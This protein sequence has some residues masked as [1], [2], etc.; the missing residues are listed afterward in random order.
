[1]DFAK[2]RYDCSLSI[3]IVLSLFLNSCDIFQ[4]V[5][6]ITG[7]SVSLS[8]PSSINEDNENAFAVNGTCSEEGRDVSV[9]VG[10][11]N[12]APQPICIGGLW[13]VVALNVSALPDGPV[14]VTADHTNANGQTAPQATDGIVKDVVD[15]MPLAYAWALSSP[16][17][18]STSNDNTPIVDLSGAGVENG[19]S[20]QVYD[21][22][23]CTNPVG[24][25]QFIIGG[26]TTHNDVSYATDG[27][28]DGA[29]DFYVVMTDGAGNPSPCSDVSLG[30]SLITFCNPALGPTYR[31][32]VDDTGSEGNSNSS[33]AKIDNSGRYVFFQSDATNLIPAD[34]NSNTDIFMKDR[35]T[36][37]VELIS[38]DSSEVQGNSSAHNVAISED[39]NYVVFDSAST[40]L[41]PVDTNA[42]RDVFLRDR[43]LGLT[44]RVSEMSGGGEASDYS[45]NPS[46][47]ADGRYIVF[48][49]VATDMVVGDLNGRRDIFL[50][51]RIANTT[52]LISV[53]SDE[54]QAT[55]HSFN[56]SVSSDGRF[57]AFQTIANNVVP[58]DTNGGTD[59]FVRD[60]LLGTT[61]RVSVS[62][63]ETEGNISSSVP[64][65]SKSGRFVVFESFASNLVSGDTNGTYDI[66]VRDRFLGITERVSVISGGGESNN[67]SRNPHISTDGNYIIFDSLA[68]NLVAGDTNGVSDI[69]VHDRVGSVTVRASLD[70]TDLF[71]ADVDAF[72]P[73]IS[74]D[75]RVVVYDSGATNLICDD[76]NGF[77]DVFGRDLQP[78]GLTVT[79][80]QA[81][82]Q[83]DPTNTT[84]VNFDVVFSSA[85]DPTSFTVADIVNLGSAQVDIWNINHVSGNTNFTI[86][87]ISVSSSG[88]IQP[89]IGMSLVYDPG[90]VLFN[91]ASTSVDGSVEF[92]VETSCDTI[93]LTACPNSC[94]AP[95]IAGFPYAAGTGTS[96]DPYVICTD[97]QMN[98][99]G[100][101][102]GDWNSHFRL[103]ADIDLS[104]FPGESYNVI[105]DL[106]T[107]FT[108]V[109]DGQGC[110]ISNLNYIDVS[111]VGILGVFGN[112]RC[113]YI[114]DLSLDVS[115][116]GRAR[117]GALAG[118]AT[119]G[120]FEN[121]DWTIGT[122]SGTELIGG[123]VGE[124]DSFPLTFSNVRSNGR[125]VNSATVAAPAVGGIVGAVEFAGVGNPTTCV[126]TEGGDYQSATAVM[127]I[128][129]I[130]SC[131]GNVESVD[132]GYAGGILG[133]IG[134]NA[135]GTHYI[136]NSFVSRTILPHTSGFVGVPGWSIGGGIFGQ[137]YGASGVIEVNKVGFVGTIEADSSIQGVDMGG[138]IGQA[139]DTMNI[140]N[141]YANA[142]IDNYYHRGGGAA[143]CT[144]GI[145]CG[146]AGI[147]IGGLIGDS[148]GNSVVL[149]RSYFNGTVYG[150]TG[151]AGILGNINNFFTESITIS[152]S[153]TVGTIFGSGTIIGND[154]GA[155]ATSSN[156]FWDDA[157]GLGLP[158]DPDN[159][160]GAGECQASGGAA[161]FNDYRNLPMGDGISIGDGTGTTWNFNSNWSPL[162]HLTVFP[163]LRL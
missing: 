47:S 133:V 66:F 135:V 23:V 5:A 119:K 138:L 76:T 92:I 88:T 16:A 102:P 148:P 116:S 125:V 6:G 31:F 4:K 162:G 112:T 153:F 13:S 120:R 80:E 41:I 86:Q 2:P 124:T 127:N 25:S 98:A 7:V 144:V 42:S 18:G 145:G 109:F 131:G 107:Q 146:G 60:R 64:T 24:S 26:A 74:S 40:N 72:R 136:T 51:D 140:Y 113:A 62:S 93:Q 108:G 14:V 103:K 126:G 77:G 22:F 39:G 158:C 21:D 37:T 87:A 69:F 147:H 75:G 35:L 123:I 49:S 30:Y 73:S 8:S 53:T 159:V 48:E 59:I 34:G 129:K 68:T 27:T 12:P 19:S 94:T 54:V 155:N 121:I 28:D 57:V 44:T 43:V 71:E 29:V 63:F 105:G 3:V 142:T 163:N 143:N 118:Y 89:Y 151:A 33:N 152:N 20:V 117:V 46:I 81:V 52:E 157:S 85:I 56:P 128:D 134:A 137:N 122:V 139:S 79:I 36:N 70:R 78:T 110:Q 104:G 149:D 17:N 65:I 106:G 114:H 100:I 161:Y 15:P 130:K 38:V 154:P 160:R 10:G 96:A 82:A 11:I 58:D 55:N 95:E 97:T 91:Y 156:N 50:H 84:A 132:G 101:N 99:I 61:E 45:E 32:S 150:G 111:L 90:A 1:M 83:V 115:V 67:E 9:S 141:S